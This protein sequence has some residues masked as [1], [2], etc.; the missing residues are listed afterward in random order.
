MAISLK[1]VDKVMSQPT[2]NY[3]DQKSKIHNRF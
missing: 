3:G 1:Q 2:E